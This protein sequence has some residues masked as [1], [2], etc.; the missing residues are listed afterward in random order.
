MSDE[1]YKIK[2][3]VRNKNGEPLPN[4]TVELSIPSKD[5]GA[6]S[7][8]NNEGLWDVKRFKDN[9]PDDKAIFTTVL[10]EKGETSKSIHLKK[11]KTDY[12]VTLSDEPSGP[13]DIVNWIKENPKKAGIG[14]LGVLAL[15]V[16]LTR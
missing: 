5:F 13:K 1:F 3:Y 8:T 7:K 9:F 6:E 4:H 15:G 11:S 10:P 12:E 16:M 14:A 2:V